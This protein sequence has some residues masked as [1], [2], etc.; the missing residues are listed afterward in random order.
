MNLFSRSLSQI[1]P[2]LLFLTLTP[3]CASNVGHFSVMATKPIA[4]LGN[5]TP[6]PIQHVQ[7]KACLHNI[8][9]VPLGTLDQ[10]EQQA[11]DDAIS[12]GRRRGVKGNALIN[13]KVEFTTLD[14]MLYGQK[15]F[16]VEGD[17][18]NLPA[19]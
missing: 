10:R 18:V 8:F 4:S 11:F 6:E 14:F 19:T 1:F 15:C 13:V 17:L 12:V 5:Q 16:T 3:G 2:L 7:G 9:I